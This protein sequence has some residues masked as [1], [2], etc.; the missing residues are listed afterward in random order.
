MALWAQRKVRLAFTNRENF[1]TV[2]GQDE[3]PTP[4]TPL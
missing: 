1:D 2:S 4:F 3:T